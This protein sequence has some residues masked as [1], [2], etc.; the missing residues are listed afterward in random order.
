MLNTEGWLPQAKALSMGQRRKVPHDCGDGLAMIVEHQSTGYRAFCF[1][2][3]ESGFVGKVPTLAE[4]QEARRRKAED[5]ALR[6]AP[7]LP[8]PMVQ[9]PREWPLEARLWL[10]KASLHDRWIKEA[11]IY[12]HPPT[13]RVV[14]PVAEDGKLVYWQARAVMPGQVPKYINPSVDKG[15]IVPVFGTGDEVVLT[16]DYLSAYRVGKVT[17]AWSLLGT[18]MKDGVLARAVRDHRPFIVWLDPDEAGRS[19]TRK[20]VRHLRTVGVQVSTIST[21]RDPKLLTH[22]EIAT[23]LQQHKQSS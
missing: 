14:L 1:R 17:E 2:C 20:I 22:E 16:E 3:N 15:K 9:E 12:Y 6:Y 11:G 7:T 4:M 19:A 23:C 5:A 13:Q 18:H 21:D 8:M 10:Y